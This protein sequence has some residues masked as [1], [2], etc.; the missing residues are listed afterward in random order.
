MVMLRCVDVP[1]GHRRS[2]GT[3]S[4]TYDVPSFDNDSDGYCSKLSDYDSP[5]SS[6]QCDSSAS[7]QSSSSSSGITP[8]KTQPTPSPGIAKRPPMKTPEISSSSSSTDDD[9]G[10][11]Y[12]VTGSELMKDIEN[13]MKAKDSRMLSASVPLSDDFGRRKQ[14]PQKPSELLLPVPKQK[15]KRRGNKVVDSS[16]E[17]DYDYTSINDLPRPLPGARH[18]GQPPK[19]RNSALSSECFQSVKVKVASEDN[20]LQIGLQFEWKTYLSS[21]AF[22]GQFAESFYDWSQKLDQGYQDASAYKGA[23]CCTIVKPAPTCQYRTTVEFLPVIPVLQWPKIASDWRDRKRASITD[24]RT[25]MKYQWPRPTQVETIVKQGCHL[26]T[27]GGKFRGRLSGNSKLEWQL[28]FGAAQETLLASLSEPHL[29]ALLWTRLIFRHVVTAIGVLSPHHIDTVFFWMVEANY[30]DWLEVSLGERI[31]A[32]FETLY[33]CIRQR[34]LPHYF[35]KKRNLLH[36][37]APKDLVKAQ[38]RLFRLME[39]F[40]PL[41]MQ[42]A[43]QLQSSNPTFP[44]PDLARLWEIATTPLT[45]DSINPGLGASSRTLSTSSSSVDEKKKKTG[46]KK[47]GDEGF[48]ETVTKNP[49][50]PTGDRTRDLLRKERA[51]IDA[52][53]REKRP[54]SNEESA[55]KVDVV[56]NAFNVTQTKLL[57]EFFIN[58]FTCMAQSS[59][60]IRA[61][62]KSTVFLDQAYNL[63]VLLR[64][65][66]FEDSAE[67]HFKTIEQLRDASYQGQFND[68]MVEIPGTP[69]VFPTGVESRPPGGVHRHSSLSNGGYRTIPLPQTPIE[70]SSNPSQANGYVKQKSTTNNNSDLNGP[71]IKSVNDNKPAN[72]TIVMTTAL[73]ENVRSSE[74]Q[75][76]GRFDKPPLAKI[77]LNK[78]TIVI[79]SDSDDLDES[80]D[81]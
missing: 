25:N 10:D 43:K 21:T 23:I 40:V 75:P 65:E 77:V 14:P 20:P 74:T 60:R 38:E 51:R 22:F 27:E 79:E 26:I 62:G 2:D 69:C 44:F 50:Q 1:A 3:Q 7:A 41:T 57:L 63:A 17:D 72:K 29:R 35:I 48:W 70:R 15:H 55:D 30:T 12:P 61:Y 31:M 71:V 11:H 56:I 5:K 53:E 78:P 33:D 6:M 64:E 24:K 37:K 67:E 49:Q 47:S 54:V 46:N 59:N 9:G 81:F 34:K 68:S 52:E 73:I 39:R 45:L 18:A 19:H 42:A 66:G 28:S 58:Q 76:T 32:I 4:T 80:T 36:S 13:R 16:S 8:I